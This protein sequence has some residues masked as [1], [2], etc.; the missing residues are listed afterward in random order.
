MESLERPAS[1]AAKRKLNVLLVTGDDSLWP[2]IGADLSASLVLKQVD[3]IDELISSTP[4]GQEGIVL[5]DARNQQDPASMLSRLNMHSTRFAIVALDS[6]SSAGAW[7]LPLQHRQVVAHVA[8]PITGSTLAKALDNAQEEVRARTALLG[9]SA[10]AAAAATTSA[11]PT[12]KLPL[13]PIAVIGGVIAA[14]V[15]AIVVMRGGSSNKGAANN[16]ASGIPTAAKNAEAAADKVDG[17][18]EKAGQAMQDRHYID[19]AAGSAL[20]LYRDVLLIDPNNGEARQGLQRLAEILITRVNSALDERKF[21]VALQSLE[22]ARSIS[23]NDP[24]FAALDERITAMRAELG[25]AQIMAALN[26]GNFDRATQLID[27][28]ARAKSL[29]AAKLAQLRDEVRKHRD[30]ADLTRIQKLID[31]RLQQDKLIDPRNDSAA[32]Y[33][34]QA[35]QAGAPTATLQAQS[36]DLEKRML[37]DTQ[38]FIDQRRFQD[39]DRFLSELHNAGVSNSALGGL[40]Q[41]LATARAQS[42]QQRPEQPQYLDLAQA[43]LAQGKLLEPDGDSA[44]YYVNQLKSTDPR[45]AGL[46]QISS[47]V[48]AQI[49]ERARGT[50]SSGDL[51][52]T[53][54][55]L[56]T[57][58]TLG[59]SSAVDSLSDQLRQKK[60]AAGERPQ[61]PEQSLTRLNKLEIS[62]PY[63]AM[64]AGTEGW[65]EL[66]YTVKPDGTVTNVQTIN[67]SPPGTFDQAASKAVTKLKYQPVIQGGRP[68]A[69][70]TQV[71]V[72]FRIPK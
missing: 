64:Q 5:W 67:S 17:L 66:G 31:T 24:R 70:D 49:A 16:P 23:P 3:S 21:D 63:R 28:A 62:Y 1:T 55:L 8:L 32:Y 51:A 41:N 68:T 45:N 60:A 6:P 4:A 36:Q 72:V 59:P 9:D 10:S 54:S 53:E 33:I 56:Q 43:R 44:L 37:A 39:A 42:A 29:P 38:R 22:T 71:R 34:E 57:A 11:G 46:A 2:Q 14:A 52:K 25:P 7:T 19:P 13:M 61:V 58:A 20:S 26:A 47:S 65:V 15:I 50:L 48:Q 40:Q 27:E 69:V 35:K 30:D 18:I 12:K